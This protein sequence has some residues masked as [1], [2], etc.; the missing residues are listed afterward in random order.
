[1]DDDGTNDELEGILG[2]KKMKFVT[3]IHQLI[4]CE[5]SYYSNKNDG[6]WLTYIT[7]NEINDDLLL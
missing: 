5:D 4:V 2:S 1:M 6:L 7:I 3:L